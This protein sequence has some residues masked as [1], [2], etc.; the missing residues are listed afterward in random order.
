MVITA[1]DAPPDT[2]PEPGRHGSSRED[3][4]D[5]YQT[6]KQVSV[7]RCMIVEVVVAG[8]TMVIE[9][10]AMAFDVIRSLACN[11]GWLVRP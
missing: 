6:T 1:A 9:E 5:L 3:E 2:A 11:A 7:G 10:R 8:A 4:Q